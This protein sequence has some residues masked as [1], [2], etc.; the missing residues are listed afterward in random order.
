MH[1]TAL[2]ED[3]ESLINYLH[4]NPISSSRT[5]DTLYRVCPREMHVQETLSWLM[6]NDYVCLEDSAFELTAIG[7]RMAQEAQ[8]STQNALL[9]PKNVFIQADIPT[10]D[11]HPLRTQTQPFRRAA[12]V[13]YL[14]AFDNPSDALPIPVL[15]GDTIGRL[16]DVSINLTHDSYISGHH[17]QFSVRMMDDRMTLCVEDLGSRNGTF[18]DGQRL[19]A[20]QITALEHGSRIEIGHTL[21]IVVKIPF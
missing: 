9:S 17:C 14:L 5:L 4:A 12:Q 8:R 7:M 19:E 13:D 20:N 1:A 16:T 11:L 2:P 10:A 15:D 6:D 18:V 3:A 21:L